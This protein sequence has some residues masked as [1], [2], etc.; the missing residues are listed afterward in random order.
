MSV[1]I[2]FLELSGLAP[3]L[4]TEAGE[5]LSYLPERKKSSVAAALGHDRSTLKKYIRMGFLSISENLTAA[6]F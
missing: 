3:A 5:C 2:A 4:R 6:D 1:F